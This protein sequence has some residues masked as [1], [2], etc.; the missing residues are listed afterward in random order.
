MPIALRFP[1]ALVLSFVGLSAPAWADFQ[2]GVDA[3]NRGDYA[4]AMREWRPLAEQGN[5]DA[6]FNV[7][8]LYAKGLGVPPNYIQARQWYKQAAAQGYAKAYFSNGQNS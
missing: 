4:S 5:A 3:Y 7:G 2:A 1:I 6:Q 8:V